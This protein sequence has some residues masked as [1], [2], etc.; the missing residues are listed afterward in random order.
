M[1]AIRVYAR[2]DLPDDKDETRRQRN[3]RFGFKDSPKLE[4][5]SAGEYLWELFTT[6]SNAIHRVDFNGYYY[7]LPPSDIISW[8]KLTNVD[9]TPREYDIISSM[10][11]VFCFELNKDKNAN[12]TK[13]M[14]EH[15]REMESKSRRRR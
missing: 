13:K 3:E 1:E 8:C 7:N 12:D 14:E 9:I 6:L 15:K 10:D 5:P 11:R 2:Y 4:I